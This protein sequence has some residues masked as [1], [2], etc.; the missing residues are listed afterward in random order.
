MPPRGWRQRLPDRA[1][2]P[3]PRSSLSPY[4][5]DPVPSLL[6]SSR[7]LVCDLQSEGGKTQLTDSAERR[8]AGPVHDVVPVLVAV[9]PI[10]P[11]RKAS[12]G[13]V[14]D[15]RGRQIPFGWAERCALE[16]QQERSPGRA[17]SDCAVSRPRVAVDDAFGAALS[18]QCRPALFELI[19]SLEKPRAFLPRRSSG[20]R[21]SLCYPNERRE[22]T[23]FDGRNRKTMETAEKL[24]E[25]RLGAGLMWWECHPEGS[26]PAGSREHGLFHLQGLDRRHALSGEPS[27]H[28]D[29]ASR[30]FPLSGSRDPHHN[31]TAETPQRV[32]SASDELGVGG[33]ETDG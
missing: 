28:S 32:L 2:S 18:R 11:F 14:G 19:K 3:W 16:I 21:D 4:A 29:L 9:S 31:V 30:G 23:E 6:S 5:G 27:G 24:G 26:R 10:S 15:G 1:P 12:E 13:V 7:I 8:V 25:V 17:G 20:G 22:S 33:G